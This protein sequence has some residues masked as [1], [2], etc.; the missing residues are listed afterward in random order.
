MKIKILYFAFLPMILLT[1]SCS[2]VNGHQFKLSYKNSALLT[3]TCD[4]CYYYSRN[5]DDTSRKTVVNRQIYGDAIKLLS[6]IKFCGLGDT[7]SDGWIRIETDTGS[8]AS[9]GVIFPNQE[10]NQTLR[11]QSSKT[12]LGQGCRESDQKRFEDFFFTY[13][14]KTG[15]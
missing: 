2:D 4:N 5:Y 9:F 15:N 6:S 8:I 10:T 13:A 3:V 11:I 12:G 7:T 14:D 1:P